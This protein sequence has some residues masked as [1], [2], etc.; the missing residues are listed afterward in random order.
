MTYVYPVVFTREEEGGF[1]VYAP[2]LPGC[3]TEAG[4]YADGIEK[5]RE[6][7]CGMLYIL[8][9]DSKSIP[10]P[11]EP[12]AV[13]CAPGDVVS[14]VDAPLDD[15]K[16]RVGNSPPYFTLNQP[17]GGKMPANADRR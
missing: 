15:Y 11:S 10:A 6:G 1:C 5:I 3:V 2:D 4:N 14:L 9:R 13:K 7:I 17:T 12:A 8:E 16:R